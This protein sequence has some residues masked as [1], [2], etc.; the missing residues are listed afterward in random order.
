MEKG[1]KEGKDLHRSRE[2]PKRATDRLQGLVCVE[3]ESIKDLSGEVEEH[4]YG[5]QGCP[6]TRCCP[7]SQNEGGRE[8][9]AC[10]KRG[11]A[12]FLCPER[13]RRTESEVKCL[14]RR[15]ASG[16]CPG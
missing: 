9:Q 2:P 8:G 11:V 15:Q 12:G 13:S 5:R 1:G 6:G 14:D 16:D 7:R 3:Y 4:Q 10:E